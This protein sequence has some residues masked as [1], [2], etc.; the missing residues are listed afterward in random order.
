MKKETG[1]CYNVMILNQFQLQA[2]QIIQGQVTPVGQ[3]PVSATQTPIALVK[4]VPTAPAVTT[5]ATNQATGLSVPQQ[6][7]A[8]GKKTACYTFKERRKICK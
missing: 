2:A 8:L 6:R 3:S 1:E 4:S 5:L 7:A